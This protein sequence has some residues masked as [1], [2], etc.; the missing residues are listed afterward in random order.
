MSFLIRQND[1]VEIGHLSIKERNI[2]V[3]P[4]VAYAACIDSSI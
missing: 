4:L 1:S 2:L 3:P